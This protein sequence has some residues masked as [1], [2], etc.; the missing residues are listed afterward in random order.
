[1]S[2]HV[3]TN[4]FPNNLVCKCDRMEDIPIS[5]Y[6]YIDNNSIYHML[7]QNI[8]CPVLTHPIYNGKG[9]YYACAQPMRDDV[10]LYRRLSPA[11]CIHKMVPE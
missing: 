8:R 6:I 3:L 1:M 7:R 10:I 2:V 9:L 5:L 11:R 4:L